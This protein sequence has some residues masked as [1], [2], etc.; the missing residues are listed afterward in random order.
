MRR[1]VRKHI[2]V[3]LCFIIM[4]TIPLASCNRGNTVQR[5]EFTVKRG[6]IQVVVSADGNLSLIRSRKLTFGIGGTIN[7]IKVKE[8]D[9]VTE[10]Q[11]LAELDTESLEIAVSITDLAVKSAA[12]DLEVA[13]N[14]FRKITYPYTYYTFAFGV[15]ES[16][17]AIGDA[18]NR[19]E[20]AE[21]GIA[22]GL[23]TAQYSEALTKL[24][25]AKD[26]LVTAREKLGR[27]QGPEVFTSGQYPITTYWT[28]REA[29][30]AMDKATITLEKAGID[31]KKAQDELPKAV[32]KAPFSGLIAESNLKEG[33]RVSSVHYISEV[34]FELIDPDTFELKATVDEVDIA[35]VAI[36]HKAVITLDALPDIAPE[37]EVTYIS[38]LSRTEGGVVV[39]DIKVSIDARKYPAMKSGMTAKADIVTNRREK[40]L[41][42]PER[43]VYTNDKGETAV[44]VLI[45]DKTEER[46]IKTG[47][48]DATQ[49]EV[50]EGLKEGEIVVVERKPSST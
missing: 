21:K 46:A 23:S 27:G 14:N 12:I 7:E 35:K 40:T 26:K 2:L 5:Q 15:P 17:A 47:I 39:Y 33:D 41:I 20:E 19:L 37:G 8:G 11:I 13:T 25:E 36:G 4:T 48:S 22:A 6:D 24:K 28:L 1:N 29:Q 31:L 45:N 32:I 18:L 3:S 30:L 16:L 42:I 9:R 44:K 43:V 38:P 49:I 50:L 10:G 34:A